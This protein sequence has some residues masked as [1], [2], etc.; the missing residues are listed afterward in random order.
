MSRPLRACLAF[1]M[2]IAGPD[3]ILRVIV[4]D[5]KVGSAAIVSIAHELQHA[6]EVL[7]YRSVRTGGEMFG[8]FHRIGTWR[9]DSFETHAAIRVGEAVRSELRNQRSRQVK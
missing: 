4:D 2:A 5:R 1:W 8:V 7:S 6:L 9:G 3:R